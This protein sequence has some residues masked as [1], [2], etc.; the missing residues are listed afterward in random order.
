LP[1]PNVS[2]AW[3]GPLTIRDRFWRF[4]G[5]N[6]AAAKPA[7]VRPALESLE[8]RDL[9]NNLM[10]SDLVSSLAP[11]AASLTTPATDATLDGSTDSS[12]MLSGLTPTAPVDRALGAQQ[13]ASQ[14]PD[15]TVIALAGNAPPSAAPLTP[16]DMLFQSALADP[17]ANPY[18]NGLFGDPLQERNQRESKGESKGTH[19]IY[20][21]G[22]F[23]SW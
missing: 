21:G 9:P 5:I 7:S 18:G 22:P 10:A 2:N 19:L 13:W 4:L 20:L 3:F 15:S 11:P 16:A 14:I 17:F 6:R 23:P 8:M 12:A 1:P